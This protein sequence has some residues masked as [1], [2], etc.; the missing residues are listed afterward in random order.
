MS[1]DRSARPPGTLGLAPIE[2]L[3]ARQPLFKVSILPLQSAVSFVR[4][5]DVQGEFLHLREQ[6][7]LHVTQAHSLLRDLFRG[8]DWPV[9]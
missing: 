8:G 5:D 7:G 3:D 9:P 2:G 1:P 6:L 4:L